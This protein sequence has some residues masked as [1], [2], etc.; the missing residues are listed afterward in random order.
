M[1]EYESR[2]G[3]YKFLNVP[4]FPMMHW[5]DNFGWIMAKFMY[6][7][8]RIVILR[9]LLVLTMWLSHV[10]KLTPFIMGHGYLS[11]PMWSKIGGMFPI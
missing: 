5:L 7:E 2:V 11:M 6:S 1:L 3:L 8:V 10:M 4:N 9:V